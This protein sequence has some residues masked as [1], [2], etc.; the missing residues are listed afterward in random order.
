MSY[1]F[2]VMEEDFIVSVAFIFLKMLFRVLGLLDFT[3]LQ[4][5][6]SNCVV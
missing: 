6:T 3:I 2:F 1:P 4:K 5:A